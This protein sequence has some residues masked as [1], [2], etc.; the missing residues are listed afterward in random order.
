MVVVPRPER[1]PPFVDVL[2]FEVQEPVAEI[3]KRQA[4]AGPTRWRAAGAEVMALLFVEL[5]GQLPIRR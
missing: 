5:R 4:V 1:D 2:P 3:E